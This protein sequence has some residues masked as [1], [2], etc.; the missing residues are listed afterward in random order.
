MRLLHVPQR[1]RM[2]VDGQDTRS[3]LGRLSDKRNSQ[4]LPD[5]QHKSPDYFS[6]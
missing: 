6:C 1:T 4:P 3:Y 5:H 2:P